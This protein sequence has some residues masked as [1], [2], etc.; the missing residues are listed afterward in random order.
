MINYMQEPLNLA[1]PAF[2]TYNLRPIGKFQFAA[3]TGINLINRIQTIVNSCIV[4]MEA[5]RYALL[6][7]RSFP[8]IRR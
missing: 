3:A 6:T 7:F 8:V 1:N 5:K 4:P 2:Y